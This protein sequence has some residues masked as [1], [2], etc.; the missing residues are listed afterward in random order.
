[1]SGIYVGI[2]GGGTRA[3]AVAI[4]ES[5]RE[6]GRRL[7]PAGIVQAADPTAA[8][9]TAADLTQRLLAELPSGSAPAAALCCGLAGAGRE[10]ERE[11]VRVA[12]ALAGV[13]ERIVIVG[14]AE[15]ALADAFAEGSGV[16]VIA[17][18]G[19]IAWAR[20]A[21]GAMVRVGGWGQLL[22]DEGSGY[23]VGIETLR[24][25]TRAADGRDPPTS[26]TA[27]VLAATGCAAPPDL[28][29]FA[30]KATKADIAALSPIT[31]QQAAAGDA[32]ARAI[33]DYTLSSLVTLATTAARL[34]E[35]DAPR[36]AFVGGLIEPG[37]P[38]HE[39]LGDALRRALPGVT[40]RTEP[41]DA[42][43]GAALLAL[44]AAAG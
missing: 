8:A 30:A 43:R 12:L 2:D 4:D 29:R 13:A 27:P 21:G 14:D 24:A 38:L 20:S 35:L 32:A 33:R 26:L 44:R 34:A 7:G 19:S 11:A 28:I 5:G 17:G 6:L 9:D 18:T 23:G 22:G 42:A 15:A 3:R 31:L 25:I 36:C 16:L 1:M 40:V 39:P 10:Q 41:V 37:S